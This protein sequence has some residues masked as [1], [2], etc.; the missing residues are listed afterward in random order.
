MWPTFPR[1]KSK[2]RAYVSTFH[3]LAMYTSASKLTSSDSSMPA[4]HT[5]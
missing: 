4:I 2:I 3:D 5:S 1:S